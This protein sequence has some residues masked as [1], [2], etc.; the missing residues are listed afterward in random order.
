M[1]RKFSLLLLSLVF[2]FFTFKAIAHAQFTNP[3]YLNTNPDV[4]QNFHTY[5]QS[6]LIEI[7][8]AISCELTGF[9]PTSPNSRCLG[10]DPKTNKIGF[11][12]NGGGAIGLM[13]GFIADTFY[14]PV[15]SHDY[16]S[17]LAANFGFT[18]KAYASTGF[19]GLQPVQKLWIAFRNITYMIFVTLFVV[20]GLGIMFRIKIDPRTV[21]TLQNQIPK[22]IIAI[23]L[24]TFSFAIAGF[25]I[26]L[27]YVF[28][29][30]I[31][32]LF[33]QQGISPVDIGSNNPF[34]AIGGLG[35]MSGIASGVSHS[36][37]GIVVSMFDGTIGKIVGAAIGAIIGQFIGKAVGMGVGTAIEPLGGGALGGMIGSVAGGLIGGVG[38]FFGSKYLIG[39]VSG[40]I[41]YVVIIIALFSALLRLWFVLIKSY[42]Y[43]LINI[44]IGPF[45][46]ASGL[47]PGRSG[48][49]NWFR[50]V[51]ANLSVFPVTII[52]MLLGKAFA[53]GFTTGNVG[54][55]AFVPPMV[56]DFSNPQVFASIIGLAIVLM[57]PEVANMVRDT[58]KTSEFKYS[59]AV[60]KGVAAGFGTA[61]GLVK[62]SVSSYRSYT[63][64]A[65][66]KLTEKG[67]GAILSRIFK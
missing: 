22:I 32:S 54:S 7:P 44:V 58:L 60:G 42:I 29:Y 46:I 3:N 61:S 13:G 35:G 27:M 31:I 2:C 12:N 33:A 6:V 43:L 10:I 24:V 16:V 19:D 1:K 34:G 51:V 15:S 11:V 50:S 17:N 23:V 14:I 63:T 64:T 5:T 57:L 21:M 37:S 36:M 30:L 28:M 9:D 47:I 67:P 48:F 45:V 38:G 59:A 52:M 4:P 25:L 39:F 55:G 40:I 62:E 18:K 20:V 66:K 56:G 49:G 65:Q 8:A 26:D 41:V 53:T